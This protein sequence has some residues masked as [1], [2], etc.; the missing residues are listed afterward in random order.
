MC[1]ASSCA[2]CFFNVPALSKV[3]SLAD[4]HYGRI[5]QQIKIMKQYPGAFT[6]MM[7][8]GM[9]GSAHRYRIKA[10]QDASLN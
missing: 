4:E 9:L 3:D 2:L 7:G 8:E 1:A 10:F 6:R 5:R